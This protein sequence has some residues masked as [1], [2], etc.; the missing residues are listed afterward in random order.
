MIDKYLDLAR[1]FK[2]RWNNK[3]TVIPCVAGALRMV[4]KEL[5]KR[6]E[7]GNEEENRDYSDHS[8]KIGSNSEKI[9]RDL[10]RLA[11]TQTPHKRL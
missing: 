4:F 8:I 6:R 2:T 7:T 9:P 3:A 11:V 1:E 5:V 10:R